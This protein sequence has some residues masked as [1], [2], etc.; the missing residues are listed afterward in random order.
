VSR[1][2]QNCESFRIGLEMGFSNF[3]GFSFGSFFIV[4]IH[5]VGKIPRISVFFFSFNFVFL[6]FLNIDFSR[7]VKNLTA[8]GTFT[9]INVTNKHDI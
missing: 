3:Y 6:K 9:G 7:Q 2:I 8:N 1:S 4:D 5:N